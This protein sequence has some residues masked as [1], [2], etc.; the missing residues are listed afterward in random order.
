MGKQAV[1]VR[2]PRE[3]IARNG[4][5]AFAEPLYFAQYYDLAPITEVIG[6]VKR[7]LNVVR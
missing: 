1:L 6:R 2:V 7:V 5:N 4:G 3:L